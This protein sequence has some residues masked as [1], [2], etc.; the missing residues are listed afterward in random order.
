MQPSG[1]LPD[2]KAAFEAVVAKF[3]TSNLV[4]S[5]QKRLAAVNEAIAKA[6]A[7]RLAEDKQRQEYEAIPE[8]SVSE[9]ASQYHA[10]AV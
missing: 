2:A 5:A 7:E 6:E 1:N 3:P 8:Y 9:L 10:N 4:A